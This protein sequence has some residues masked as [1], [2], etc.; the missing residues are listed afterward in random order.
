MCNL[1]KFNNN[2]Q[3]PAKQPKLIKGLITAVFQIQKSTNYL[4]VN[5]FMQALQHKHCVG[6]F[7]SR[8][9]DQG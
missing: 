1:Y 8:V 9:H 2:Y 3:Y 5:A 6:I 7:E 4:N